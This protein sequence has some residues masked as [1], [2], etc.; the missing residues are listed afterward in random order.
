MTPATC[1]VCGD[2]PNPLGCLVALGW[3]SDAEAS[4]YRWA[5]R[6]CAER[7]G[8]LVPPPARRRVA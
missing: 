6:I 2:G 3:F 4:G 8:L 1:T 5:H 7:A